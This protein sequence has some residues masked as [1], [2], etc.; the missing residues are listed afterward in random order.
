MIL[1]ARVMIRGKQDWNMPIQNSLETV[2]PIKLSHVE[3]K[4]VYFP[5]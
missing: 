2:Q 5:E 4:I 1:K 3:G